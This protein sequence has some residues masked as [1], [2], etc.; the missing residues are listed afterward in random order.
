MQMKSTTGE[1]SGI[2]AWVSAL[3]CTTGSTHLQTT[4]VFLR[5]PGRYTQQLG[6][7]RAENRGGQ[8]DGSASDN[9]GRHTGGRGHCSCSYRCRCPRSSYSG[10]RWPSYI[11]AAGP[12]GA[13][14]FSCCCARPVGP[15]GR[16][17]CAGPSGVERARIGRR[18]VRVCT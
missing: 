17:C 14:L 1:Q 10:G 5:S 9:T 4:V 16:R 18:G 15:L 7:Q 6:N 11:R 3:Y 13:S 2:K 8:K 12:S